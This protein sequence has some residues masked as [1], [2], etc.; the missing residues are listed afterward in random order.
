MVPV[1]C[2]E[3]GG[4]TASP[5]A[6]ESHG[7]PRALALLPDHYY[8]HLCLATLG[9]LLP[10]G[11][12]PGVHRLASAFLC[13]PGEVVGFFWLFFTLF[14]EPKGCLQANVNHCLL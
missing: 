8:T 3:A 6:A 7:A 12:A 13:P 9:T 1:M 10:A 11:G 5:E 14:F 2:R 4:E